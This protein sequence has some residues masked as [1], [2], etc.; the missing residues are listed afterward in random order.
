MLR[1]NGDLHDQQDCY[2]GLI[3]CYNV[4]TVFTPSVLTYFKL[5]HTYYKSLLS[6]CC[7]LVRCLKC[8]DRM[9]NSVDQ[10]VYLGVVAFGSPLFLQIYLFDTVRLYDYGQYAF[11]RLMIQL[12]TVNAS[13]K[14]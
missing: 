9:A 12:Y 1:S 8:F 7:Y 13:F 14:Y 10:T 11:E 5:Y 2:Y 6:P 4:S 3:Y